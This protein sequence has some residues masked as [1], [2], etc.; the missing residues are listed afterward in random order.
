MW[1]DRF[2]NVGQAEMRMLL[3]AAVA[4]DPANARA[5][6]ELLDLSGRIDG[7]E[8]IAAFESLLES[9]AAFAFAHGKGESNRTRFRNCFDLAYRLMRLDQKSN[10][11]AKLVAL[12]M[13]IAAGEK[14]FGKWWENDLSRFAYRNEND[15]PEDV[16][17]CLAL[18]VDEADAAA[19][20]RLD[21][22]W[23]P[24]PDCPAK[25]QL[26][27]RL[28]HGLAA[29]KAPDIG[30]Q[31][32]GAGVRLIAASGNVLALARDEKY[33]YVGHPWGVDVYDQAGE[34]LT[35]IALGEPVGALAAAGGG[36]A[37]GSPRGLFRIEPG[38]WTVVHLWLDGDLRQRTAPAA[39]SP[40]RP[41]TRSTMASPPSCPTAMN[42]GSP[43]TATF[44]GS[45]RGP[46]SCG[47]FRYGNCTPIPGSA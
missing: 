20:A 21:A 30:W 40:G 5:R 27:R 14:P 7:P 17:A 41:T 44:N 31:H 15:W 42:C 19:L 22:M 23:K 46:W 39:R 35:R 32:L 3:E 24:L 6:L 26:S 43:C 1:L 38:A 13:R 47:P 2:R 8:A 11:Q 12:G 36:G 45:T 29:A 33:V 10:E 18:L 37:A 9:D 34:P 28:A 25:R 16:N 4:A